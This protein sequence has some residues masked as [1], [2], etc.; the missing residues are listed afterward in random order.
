MVVPE[1]PFED[2]LFHPKD[3]QQILFSNRRRIEN[4]LLTHTKAL[5]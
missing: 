1:K 5:S 2:I 4:S 3:L